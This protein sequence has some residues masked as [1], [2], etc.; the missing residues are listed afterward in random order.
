MKVAFRSN[1]EGVLPTTRRAVQTAIPFTAGEPWSRG[2][3]RLFVA[4][5]IFSH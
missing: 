2:G 3:G 1:T 4:R 5:H